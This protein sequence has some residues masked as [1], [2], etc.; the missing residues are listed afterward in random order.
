MTALS[1][2][3]VGAYGHDGYVFPLDVMSEGEART[4]RAQLEAIERHAKG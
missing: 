4:F 2:D 1:M 3:Q